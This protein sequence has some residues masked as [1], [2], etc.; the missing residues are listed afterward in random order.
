MAPPASS[1]ARAKARRKIEYVPLVREIDTFGGRDINHIMNELLRL[2]RGQQLRDINDWG[3]VYV[4][5]LTMSLRSRI[6]TELSY[7]LTTL[8]ILSTM[9]STTPDSGFMIGNCEELLSEVLDLLEELSFPDDIDSGI[10]PESTEVITNRQLI[11]LAY[12]GIASPFA[13]EEKVQGEYDPSQPGPT[14]RRADIIRLILNILRNLSA[15]TDN[16]AF[17]AQHPMT[18]D[19]LLRLTQLQ[20][21]EGKSPQPASDALSLPDLILVRKDVLNILVNLA[22][23]ISLSPPPSSDSTSP[24]QATTS[25]RAEL[26]HNL[27]ASYLI[28]PFEAVSPFTW[29]VQCGNNLVTSIRVPLLPD[30][31]LEVFTRV[32]QPDSNRKVFSSSIPQAQIWALFEALVHRLPISEHDFKLI[33]RD[34]WISYLTKLVLGLYSLAFIMPPELKRRVKEDRSLGFAKVMM[35]VVKRTMSGGPSMA[36]IR[37]IFG[38]CARRAV[39]TMKIIDDGANSFDSSQPSVPTLSF[40]VG[41]GEVGDKKI[42]KGSGLLGGHGDDLL[43]SVMLQKELDEVMF[44]ELESLARVEAVY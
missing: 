32:S 22:G 27:V 15:V 19:L 18:I 36:E 14:Q 5:A 28:D 33:M 42:E 8:I 39:E 43:V 34:E 35:R 11:N 26:V 13:A 38:F 17:M 37:T 25:R 9:R 4:D 29:A 41:Y 10:R 24:D 23:T 20:I 40:G 31:A 16:Q 21:R 30:A 1:S 6:S 7:G 3:K 12:E 2:S 44:S